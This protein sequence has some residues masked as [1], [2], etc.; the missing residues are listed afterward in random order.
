MS[1]DN[2]TFE[3]LK[4]EQDALWAEENS[5]PAPPGYE[6]YVRELLREGI[7]YCNRPDAVFHSNEDAKRIMEEHRRKWRAMERKSA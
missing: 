7:E 1:D 5:R 4:A 2:R 6:E 3:E